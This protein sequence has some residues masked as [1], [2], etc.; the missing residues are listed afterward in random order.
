MSSLRPSPARILAACACCSACVLASP[1]RADIAAAQVVGDGLPQALTSTPGDAAH[2]HALLLAR[3][4]ANC[5]LCHALP[6]VR[7]SGNL[8]PSLAGV[9]AR[10]SAAQLRLRVADNRRVHPDTI[11]PSYFRSEG[12]TGVAARYR[13]RTVLTAQEIEDL[14]AYLQTLK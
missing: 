14:V 1:A 13:G 5:I 10:L 6:D 8:G 4:N 3:E 12:L 2:G 11:M 9:G 7:F